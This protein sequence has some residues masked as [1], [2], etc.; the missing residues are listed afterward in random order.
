MEEKLVAVIEREMKL[1][2]VPLHA[3]RLQFLNA[4]WD[5]ANRDISFREIVE[6]QLNLYVGIPDPRNLYEHC[7]SPKHLIRNRML[8]W[9]IDHQ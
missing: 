1:S 4:M 6:A 5:Y 8:T 9:A 7:N 2:H 3:A